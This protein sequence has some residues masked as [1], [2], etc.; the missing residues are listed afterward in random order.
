MFHSNAEVEDSMMGKEHRGKGL[1]CL[2]NGVLSGYIFLHRGQET[3]QRILGKNLIQ[4]TKNLDDRYHLFMQCFQLLSC[5][6][7]QGMLLYIQD[8]P[9]LVR[10]YMS[11]KLY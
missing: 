7:K 3:G 9:L 11:C 2:G 8:L 10:L 1:V 5:E 6:G 4:S